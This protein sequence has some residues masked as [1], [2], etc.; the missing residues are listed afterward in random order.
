MTIALQLATDALAIIG[1]GCIGAVTWRY[2]TAR[3]DDTLHPPAY[4]PEK[5]RK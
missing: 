4:I 2:L 5:Y 1:G 3:P